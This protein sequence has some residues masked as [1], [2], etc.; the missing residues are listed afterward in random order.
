MNN[1]DIQGNYNQSVGLVKQETAEEKVQLS[2][3]DLLQQVTSI[4][5][6]MKAVMR[7]DE[8]YGVIPG[9]G[10]KPSLLKPGA[11]KLALMFRLAPSYNI[12]RRD[13]GHGHIEY[14]V[15]CTLTHIPTGKFF[16]QGVGSA[17]SMESK[18]RFRWDNTGIDVPNEYWTTRD[19]SL[20]GGASFS[21][22][23]VKGKWLIY[24]RVEHDNPADYYNTILKMAK[25][26][27]QVDATLT[28]TAASDIFTQDVEDMADNGVIDTDSDHKVVDQTRKDE[29]G[30]K[31][32]WLNKTRKDSDEYTQEWKAV[33]A[34]LDKDPS[35]LNKIRD[36]FK[37][38]KKL[39]AELEE[40]CNRD[41]VDSGE[42]GLPF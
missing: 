9:T 39:Y 32:P 27:A 16:G 29:H 20:I 6:A 41:F 11:E 17:T 36:G 18:Y 42:Q 22:R 31:K 34:R 12:T 19:E 30:D 13:L 10:N 7:K 5:N 37:V 40:Y 4:Q 8:H 23:K 24:K 38:N 25:K 21:P 1:N 33:L 26:R 15:V 2:T 3:N 35:Q 28:A 14:E